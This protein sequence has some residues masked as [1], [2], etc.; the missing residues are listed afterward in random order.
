M[1]ED[2]IDG[3]MH[4]A[5]ATIAREDSVDDKAAESGPGRYAVSMRRS[6]LGDRLICLSAAW[7]FARTTGRTLVAD[8]QSTLYSQSRA[9]SSFTL[10]FEPLTDL[11]GVPFICDRPLASLT[12]PKPRHPAIWND[13]TM[14]AAPRHRP[15]D[16]V[17]ADRDAAVALITS[18]ADEPAPTVVFDACING[19]MVSL[20][21]SRTVMRALRPLPPVSRAV[22]AFRDE[23]LAGAPFIGLHMRHGNGTVSGH[24]PYWE[25]FETALARCERAVWLARERLGQDVPVLLCTDSLEVQQAIR[26]RI[27]GIV[28]RGKAF[29]P[30][31]AGELH[32]GADSFRGRDDALVEMLLLAEASALIRYPP[33]SFFTYYATATRRWLDPPPATVADALRPHDPSD[34]LGPALLV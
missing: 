2:T 28:E 21:D 10:F 13:D 11:A 8:W 1:D 16:A 25:S 14:L 20:A 27:P 34:P 5:E 19:A 24:A 4:T 22:A 3:R 31:G 29:R 6:G 23:A 33:G 7:C 9:E 26:H 32:V 12:L 17:I 18:G 15:V 30:P